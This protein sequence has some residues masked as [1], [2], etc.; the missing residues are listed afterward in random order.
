M[1]KFE[2]PDDHK[3]SVLED[4]IGI[5]LPGGWR[6]IRRLT[7]KAYQSGGCFSVGYLVERAKEQAFMKAFDFWDA[8][9]KNDPIAAL[10]E[11]TETYLF[12]REL[13]E[14][15]GSAKMTKV[16][17]AISNGTVADKRAPLG[18]LFYLLFELADGDVRAH[19][20][21]DATSGIAWRMRCVHHIGT[22]LQ[23]LH[24][25]GIHHQDL[26]PS[27]VLVFKRTDESKIGDLGRAHWIERAAPHDGLKIAGAFRYAPPELL[28]GAPLSD[29]SLQKAASDLYLFGSMICY[30]VTG[31]P[32]TPLLLEKM[33]PEHAPFMASGGWKGFFHDALPYVVAAYDEALKE[34]EANLVQETNGLANAQAIVADTMELLRYATNPDP[35]LRG[36]PATRRK[37]HG[38]PFE[39]ER[40]V[41]AADLLARR[42]MLRSLPGA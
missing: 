33:L 8:L 14:M 3:E 16:V 41:A 7:R 18:Q 13:L 4:L 32:L 39:M 12:E 17:R 28:Y 19:L 42:M 15:C 37:K 21:E 38:N 31:V 34:V 25:Q 10:N 1:S 26:K 9:Q 29:A 24:R 36:H 11:L 6:V 2:Y 27:N 23:Q 35:E 20:V 30:F 40:F 5:E 22:A